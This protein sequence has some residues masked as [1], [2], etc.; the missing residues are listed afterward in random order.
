MG[1][2]PSPISTQVLQRDRYAELMSVIAI[3]GSSL[4]KFATEVRGLQKTELREVEEPFPRGSEGF[5]RD[6]A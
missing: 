1:L 6:A 2:T 3:T 5:L 4:E